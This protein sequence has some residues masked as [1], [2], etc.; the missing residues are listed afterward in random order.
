[1]GDYIREHDIQTFRVTLVW[2]CF[3]EKAPLANSFAN[4]STINPHFY[5]GW[6]LGTVRTIEKT[7][8]QRTQVH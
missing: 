2:P 7:I 4:K 6:Y 8:L 5:R 1:M 3:F